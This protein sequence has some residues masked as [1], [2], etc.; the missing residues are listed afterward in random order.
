MYETKALTLTG[1]TKVQMS[2]NIISCQEYG[3]AGPQTLRLG[4]I[5]PYIQSRK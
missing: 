2:E 3:A 4:D 5:Q 1:M